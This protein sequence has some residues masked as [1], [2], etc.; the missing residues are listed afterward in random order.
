MA[1]SETSKSP[2][3]LVFMTDQH[4]PSV[5]G[6]SGDAVVRTPTLDR[7]AARGTRFADCYC[8]SP[9]CVPSRMSFMTARYPHRNRVWCNRHILSS[10][11]PTF[12]HA[13]GIAGYSTAL[14]GRMHFEGPDQLHGFEARPFGEYCANHPGVPRPGG[15]AFTVVPRK[16]TGQTREAVEIA[17]RGR[18][19]Y[20]WYDE[21]VTEAASSFI[22]NHAG[23]ADDRPFAAVVGYVLPHCPFIGDRELFDY[24]YE[25][26]TI[27]SVEERQPST[28]TR[29]R[30][31]RDILGPY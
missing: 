1:K 19:S 3:F 5:M 11:I 7:L 30:R 22:E 15:P 31:D 2:N 27:P 29:F 16:T 10:A 13:L 26:V 14:I 6:C 18:G 28:I 9:L 20:Q 4:N 24:Y 21:R 8:P 17:G 12:A 25:R 23:S